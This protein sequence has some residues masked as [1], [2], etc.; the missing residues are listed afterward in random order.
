[1]WLTARVRQRE[2]TALDEQPLMQPRPKYWCARWLQ[3]VERLA[4]EMAKYDPAWLEQPLPPDD[5]D[6]CFQ[7]GFAMGRRLLGG[8]ARARLWF[9][10]YSWGTALEVTAAAHP[11]VWWPET[12]VAGGLL[13]PRAS[14]L[15]VT[16]NES[17]I[18][19][20]PWIG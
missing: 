6:V 9:A 15:G 7:G 1:M 3:T 19:R 14:G 12:V 17:V 5:Q 11:G 18:E 2:S 13:V 16:V 4:R 8:I 10:F 20:Y